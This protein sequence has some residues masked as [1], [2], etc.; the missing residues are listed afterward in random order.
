MNAVVLPWMMLS[1]PFLLYLFK[2]IQRRYLYTAREVARLMGISKTPVYS[3]FARSLE[4]LACIRAGRLQ[5]Q[6]EAKFLEYVETCN[7]PYLLFWSG[8]RW[9]GLRLDCLSASVII[10]SVSCIVLLRD[11]ISAG[12]AGAAINQIFLL[13]SYFQ[14]SVRCAA[15]VEN[16]F[17]SVERVREYALLPSEE[18]RAVL[19]RQAAGKPAAPA[20][21]FP[22]GGAVQVFPAKPRGELRLVGL[23]M[24]YRPHLPLALSAVDLTVPAG[25]RAGVI[26][27]TGAGK[28]SL[29]QVIFRF[30][31]PAAGRCEI[32][33]VD[34][35]TLELSVVRAAVATI[36]QKPVLFKASLRANLDPGGLHSDQ[37]LLQALEQCQMVT[38]LQLKVV[39]KKKPAGEAGKDLMLLPPAADAADA[40]AAAVL[41]YEV[42]E[43]GSNFSVGECQLLCLAR[44]MLRPAC[45]LLIMDEATAA[46][47]VEADK[48]IQRTVDTMSTE[49]GLTVLTIAHRCAGPRRVTALTLR[50]Q[51]LRG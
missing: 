16:L 35:S 6:F 40:D 31:E 49:R 8:T 42:A 19:S 13:T 4:G 23:S 28:S 37:A 50:L 11:H 32:D 9:L 1:L 21:V 47:D 5:P 10:V 7:R 17:T 24:R 48:L 26:G 12:V 38:N 25:T 46:V 41:D 51:L 3:H 29:L 44:A 18:A 2:A 20:K 45:K 14:Y 43:D 22:P 39:Q 27:R 15:E 30:V 34:I 33:G 36:P